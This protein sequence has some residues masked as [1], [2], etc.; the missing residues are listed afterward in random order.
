MK[1]AKVLKAMKTAKTVMKRAKKEMKAKPKAKV[2]KAATK[3]GA[4]GHE[5]GSA[6][7]VDEATT[8]TKS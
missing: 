6:E 4:E 5:E 7:T 1:R 3:K 8:T 2:M